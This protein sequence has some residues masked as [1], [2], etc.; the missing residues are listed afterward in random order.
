MDEP[1]CYTTQV[2]TLVEPLCPSSTISQSGLRTLTMAQRDSLPS[3]V[4]MPHVV[5]VDRIRTVHLLFHEWPMNFKPSSVRHLTLTN[6]LA[7]MESFS[8]LPTGVRSMQLALRRVL[9]N[10]SPGNW[11]IL[12]SL[13]ALTMLTSLYI[14]LDDV[15]EDI[16]EASCQIIAETALRLVHFGIYFRRQVILPT[17]DIPTSMDHLDHQDLD[18]DLEAISN[19]SFEDYFGPVDYMH[20]HC[21]FEQCRAAIEQIRRCIL[22]GSCS[23]EPLIVIEEEGCGLTAWL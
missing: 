13:S 22:R 5:Q 10:S 16:D 20:W 17:P 8:S 9:P 12:Q 14:I 1:I 2:E 23:P 11:R 7:N 15:C 3:I 19:D 18:V 6:S 4:A 21:I